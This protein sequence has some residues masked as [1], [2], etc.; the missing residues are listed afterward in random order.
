MRIIIGAFAL[1]CSSAF[2]GPLDNAW[3]KGTTDKNPLFYEPGETMTFKLELM[4]VEGQIPEGEYFIKWTR[5]DDIGTPFATGVVPLTKEPFIY[6]TSLD[7]PGFVRLEAYIQDKN[8]KRFKRK[9]QGDDTTPEGQ[10]ARNRFERK[11]NYVFFD[12]GA[13]VKIDTLTA[14]G[15]PKDFDEFWANQFKR[16]ENVPFREVL[17]EIP[18]IN[19]KV[20]FYA[21]RVDCA[22]N[23]PVTGY[24]SVPKAVDEG[25]TFP[26]RL[27]LHGYSADDCVHRH[28]G[29]LP[30]EEIRLNLNA[31]GL[32]LREFGAT[33]ADKKALLW[34]IRSNNHTYAFDPKQNKDPETAYFNGMVL[35]VKRALQYLKTV[36]GWNGR[37][38]IAAGS[39][40]GGLQAIWGAACGE[41]VTLAESSVTWCCELS[42][43]NERLAK[44]IATCGWYIKWVPALGYYD[45]TFFAKRIPKSCRV[46]IPRAALGDYTCPPSGLAVLWNSLNCP[47]KIVW[48]QGSQHGYVPPVKYEG[49]DF[50]REEK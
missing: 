14:K 37:D 1:I 16:L 12:G 24:L 34:E 40:Q 20:R 5:S 28:P 7:K 25:K 33:D 15:E 39:S 45:A 44:K 27:L 11:S 9:F 23:R 26:C 2:A 41:G 36:K 18:S 19:D 8:G 31:H 46:V 47:K 13:G 48:V 30:D 50:I 22:G 42:R 29:F 49:R 32:K 3:I 21:L 17:I 43:N 6:T 38:L 35:R 10:R 4:D